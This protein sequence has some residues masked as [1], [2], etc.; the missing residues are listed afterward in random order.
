MATKIVAVPTITLN[1]KGKSL[2]VQVGSNESLLSAL[3]NR[4]GL[5]GTKYGCGEAQ[6]GACTVLVDGR[7]VRSCRR[8]AASATDKKISTI[9]GLTQNGTL[10][11]LQQAFLDEEAFQCGYCT[12]GMIMAAAALLST[13]PNPND[14][15]IIQH[16]NGNICRC[17]T[18]PRII[19]AIRRAGGRKA[20]NSNNTQLS[21]CAIFS[22]SVVEMYFATWAQD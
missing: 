10:H 7:P 21:D 3:R 13:N 5:T 15:E 20:R 6:C 4:L 8:P 18:Y 11:P 22:N 14:E 12:P 19:A 16:M 9:D 17:G 2:E 1:V